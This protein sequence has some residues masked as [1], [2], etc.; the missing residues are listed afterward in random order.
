MKKKLAI[1]TILIFTAFS[2]VATSLCMIKEDVHA[3][4]CVTDNLTVKIG[5]WGMSSDDYVTK[6]TFTWGQLNSALPVYEDAFS[7]FRQEKSGDYSTII[8]SARGFA[9]SN[10]FTYLNIDTNNITNVSFYTRDVEVGYFCSFTYN[11]LFTSHRY[12]FN[13][14]NYYLIPKFNEKDE[15]VGYD[16]DNDVWD[17]KWS[18]EPML[19]LEDRWDTYEAEQMGGTEPVFSGLSTGNRFRLL[20]GQ[21]SPTEAKTNQTAKYVHTV[22]IAYSGTPTVVNKTRPISGAVGTHTARFQVDAGDEGMVSSLAGLMQWNS[23]NE[24][25]LTIENVKMSASSEFN[26]IVDVEIE[27]KI[28]KSGEASIAGSYEGIDINSDV[29]AVSESSG[30]NS[31]DGGDGDSD[32]SDSGDMGLLSSSGDDGGEE[33]AKS[34]KPQAYALSD[35]VASMLSEAKAKSDLAKAYEDSIEVNKEDL[36]FVPYIIII[37][38]LLLLAGIIWQ[39]RDFAKK[40]THHA[41]TCLLYSAMWA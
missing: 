2:V 41:K 21:T 32:S 6:G 14:L 29:L 3:A 9:I 27:Y 38:I 20:F 7:F 13:D 16:L 17:D 26:N 36:N 12:Y 15:V 37:A 10:L 22:L 35:N 40:T 30:K 31:G 25:V 24:D 11:E 28:K 19:A 39:K 4:G 33:T 18:V 8:D 23:T 34:G 5:Y 1:I